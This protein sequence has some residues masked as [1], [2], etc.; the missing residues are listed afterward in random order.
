MLTDVQKGHCLYSPQSRALYQALTLA[1]IP[2]SQSTEA[3]PPV[4]SRPQRGHDQEQ[5]ETD[6]TPLSPR[7]D[8]VQEEEVK[9]EVTEETD[10]VVVSS[11]SPEQSVADDYEARAAARRARRQKR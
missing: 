11:L 8:D 4:A 5:E 10:S 7:S 6:E 3:P 1:P 2:P 9:E